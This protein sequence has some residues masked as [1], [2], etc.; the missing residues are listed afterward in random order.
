MEERN[1]VSEPRPETPERLRR[2]R[3]LGHEDDRA[4]P[5]L[6]GRLAG[7]EVDLGLA[8]PRGPV[9]Q[10]IPP[11]AGVEAA[12]DPF[13]RSLLLGAQ[14]LGRRLGAERLPLP[15]RRLLGATGALE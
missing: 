3:D 5:A 10:E 7:A 4:E 1:P 2:Q 12:H 15:R 14:T 13:D 8:A 6:E 11:A 9:E